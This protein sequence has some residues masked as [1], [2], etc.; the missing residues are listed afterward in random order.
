MACLDP[1]DG[2]FL[3]E[4]GMLAIV[5]I[6]HPTAGRIG[7]EFILQHTRQHKELFAA[8]M[9]LRKEA[10]IGGPAVQRCHFSREVMQWLYLQVA[11]GGKPVALAAIDTH[12]RII[13]GIELVQLDQQH[14]SFFTQWRMPGLRRAAQIGPSRVIAMFIGDNYFED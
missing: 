10:T 2:I 6:S 3:N 14:T 7:T 13:G 4:A 1:G 11:L 5:R 9:L 8:K 12:S